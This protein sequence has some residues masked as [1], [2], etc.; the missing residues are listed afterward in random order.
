MPV[1]APV[2]LNQ[3]ST[4]PAGVSFVTASV[5]VTNGDLVIILL[6]DVDGN[7]I[8]SV[9]QGFSATSWTVGAGGGTTYGTTAFNLA[10]AHCQ[11]TASGSGTITVTLAGGAF[12]RVN[13]HIYRV[14]AGFNTSTPI[15]QAKRY[16]QTS[17]LTS[18]S[19]ITGTFDSAPSANSALLTLAVAAA[20]N[21]DWDVLTG[22][23]E[24]SESYGGTIPTHSAYDTGSTSTSFGA[25]L[26]VGTQDDIAAVL[27]IEIQEAPTQTHYYGIYSSGN[28]AGATDANVKAGT[29]TGIITSGSQGSVAS[30]TEQ[31][32]AVS[33]LAPNT[34]YDLE[35]VASNASGDTRGTS[36]SFT[37]KKEAGKIV[38]LTPPP[39]VRT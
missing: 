24:G 1:S 2:Y 27:G 6:T 14:P 25:T 7:D 18:G 30:G 17:P 28:G 9:T 20:Q 26:A 21:Y 4:S 22:W 39:I 19:N 35:W 3:Y 12:N 29:G 36:V 37:T 23:T 31:Q 33:G 11:A 16:S 34:T 10:Y 5:T 13:C 38:I 8:S 15:A 32:F